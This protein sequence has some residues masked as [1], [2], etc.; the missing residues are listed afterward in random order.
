MTNTV[1]VP[2]PIAATTKLLT[3]SANHPAMAA[4]ARGTFQRLNRGRPIASFHPSPST[5]FYMVHPPRGD[6]VVS[7]HNLMSYRLFGLTG[8]C[9]VTRRMHHIEHLMRTV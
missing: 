3:N 7:R 8:G 2:K 5:V 9:N 4:T 6:T 1:Y